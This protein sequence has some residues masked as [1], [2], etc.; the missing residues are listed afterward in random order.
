MANTLVVILS[1]SVIAEIAVS[2]RYHN[3]S[4]LSVSDLPCTVYCNDTSSCSHLEIHTSPTTDFNL[5][6]NGDRSCQHLTVH[7]SSITSTMQNVSTTISIECNGQQSCLSSIFEMY[8]SHQIS[9]RCTQSSSCIDIDITAPNVS[10]VTIDLVDSCSTMVS[11]QCIDASICYTYCDAKH[12]SIRSSSFKVISTV[13]ATEC[14][15]QRFGTSCTHLINQTEHERPCNSLGPYDTLDNITSKVIW[16][17]QQENNCFDATYHSRLICNTPECH[18]YCGY[19]TDC[20]ENVHVVDASQSDSFVFE[21][22]IYSG[23]CSNFDILCPPLPVN[24]AIA[25]ASDLYHNDTNCVMRCTNHHLC[26]DVNVYVPDDGMFNM[27]CDINACSNVTIYADHASAV[28]INCD[29]ST[30]PLG[31]LLFARY[32]QYIYLYSLKNSIVYAEYSHVVVLRSSTGLNLYANYSNQITFDEQNVNLTHIH[33]FADHASMINMAVI[34]NYAVRHMSLHASYAAYVYIEAFGS[35]SLMDSSIVASKASMLSV[36]CY[37][38]YTCMGSEFYLSSTQTTMNCKG[39]GCTNMSLRVDENGITHNRY[40][41]NVN[42]CGQCS[43]IKE[44]TNDLNVY[45][46]TCSDSISTTA[47]MNTTFIDDP[48]LCEEIPVLPPLPTPFVIDYATAYNSDVF[49]ITSIALSVICSA[50]LCVIFAFVLCAIARYAHQRFNRRYIS[51]RPHD[52]ILWASFVCEILI[53]IATYWWMFKATLFY[54]TTVEYCDATYNPKYYDDGKYASS[55]EW[56]YPNGT[57]PLRQCDNDPICEAT[58]RDSWSVSECADHTSSYDIWDC[59]CAPVQSHKALMI[60]WWIVIGFLTL[61]ELGRCL[62]CCVKNYITVDHTQDITIGRNIAN[63]CFALLC[64]YWCTHMCAIHCIWW[65]Y[66]FK[67]NVWKQTFVEQIFWKR[68]LWKAPRTDS[69]C[70]LFFYGCDLVFRYGANIIFAVLFWFMYSNQVVGADAGMKYYDVVPVAMLIAVKCALQLYY[71]RGNEYDLREDWPHVIDEVL[72]DEFGDQLGRLI[73]EYVPIFYDEKLCPSWLIMKDYVSSDGCVSI[74][75]DDDDDDDYLLMTDDN[76]TDKNRGT[77]L[78]TLQASLD[79][80]DS[81]DDCKCMGNESDHG[82][83]LV[84]QTTARK[85]NAYN[86]LLDDNLDPK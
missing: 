19:M 22:A 25:T 8:D 32:A 43:S 53:F 80:D 18:I 78:I 83:V 63:N 2:V 6:C 71:V 54:I 12:L 20:V 56:P 69:R 5:Y 75:V 84:V 31:V 15:S 46:D 34:G 23:S 1:A 50:A 52:F 24:Y 70:I 68:V 47:W 17:I 61:I 67:D 74:H 35:Y 81:K 76:A 26:N 85:E 66:C 27:D 48:D 29:G 37:G 21:C 51:K 64:L 79:N 72:M 3:C 65:R 49:Y 73:E 30:D 59:E 11:I 77:E 86:P 60:I 4:S 9:L 36:L 82:D 44:C 45:C 14:L 57:L 40:Q 39:V 62:C 38:Y 10:I 58:S 28:G 42:G 33:V 41:F 7:G 13:P 16:D 55:L